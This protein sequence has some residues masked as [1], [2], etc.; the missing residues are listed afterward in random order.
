[1]SLECHEVDPTAC[2][3]MKQKIHNMCD[4]ACW[5]QACPQTCGKCA[6]CYSCDLVSHPRC[7]T[8]TTVCEPGEQCYSMKH[9]STD[10]GYAYKLGCLKQQACSRLRTSFSNIFGRRDEIELPLDGDCCQGDFCNKVV[11]RHSTT[12]TTTTT[13]TTTAPMTTTAQ[14]TTM[15]T[16][17]TTRDPLGICKS[18]T[19]FAITRI[20]NLHFNKFV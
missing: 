15:P 18:N 17:T 11:L 19:E 13:P 20:H 9:F 1:M 10:G 7:C 14:T 16:T 5:V 12:S 3:I 4:E 2:Q 6:S 8:N